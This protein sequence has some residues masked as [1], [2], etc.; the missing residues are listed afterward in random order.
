MLK[1]S[2]RLPAGALDAVLAEEGV[3]G[4]HLE[5]R[6]QAGHVDSLVTHLAD[7]KTVL[8]NRA[9]ADAANFAIAALPISHR[10]PLDETYFQ[11]GLMAV[12]VVSL[13]TAHTSNHHD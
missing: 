4:K 5:R 6:S 3:P 12:C 2:H 9:A 1:W 10:S 11:L 7:E 8:F 13:A